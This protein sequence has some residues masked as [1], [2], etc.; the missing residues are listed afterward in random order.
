[1]TTT[2]AEYPTSSEGHGLVPEDVKPEACRRLGCKIGFRRGVFPP[3]PGYAAWLC[4]WAGG[5]LSAQED[6]YAIPL[7]WLNDVG[8]DLWAE[9]V[10]WLESL[11]ESAD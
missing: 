3:P 5:N 10:P 11:H 1:M 8:K 2:E 4:H 7:A 6:P 9:V